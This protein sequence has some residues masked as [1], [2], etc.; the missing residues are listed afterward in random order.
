DTILMRTDRPEIYVSHDAGN[1]WLELVVQGNNFTEIFPHTYKRN[2]VFLLT[3][4]GQVQ[5][6]T[7]QAVNFQTFFPP[8]PPTS[9][10]LEPL[11]F[12][13]AHT[14]WLLW[15][16]QQKCPEPTN[17][18]DCTTLYISKDFGTS[19][20]NLLSDVH[21]CRFV[22]SD[23]SWNKENLIYCERYED[24][25][26]QLL[27]SD[28]FF[29]TWKIL[30]ANVIPEFVK[31]SEYVYIIV[32][33]ANEKGVDLQI[34]DDGLS[35]YKGEFP[36]T[37][38]RF[39]G[40]SI[41][42]SPTHCLFA[43]LSTGNNKGAAYGTLVKDSGRG[44][45]FVS[46]L[47][48]VNRI[49][50]GEVDF[51]RINGLEGIIIINIVSNLRAAIRGEPKK[52]KTKISFNDGADW[53]LIPPPSHDADGLLLGCSGATG[54]C[55][56]HLH[57]RSESRET[58]QIHP[59][60]NER[61]RSRSPISSLQGVGIAIA[62]GNVGESLTGKEDAHMFMTRDGGVTWTHIAEGE[63][64]WAYGVQ[65]SLTVISSAIKETNHIKYSVNE[66]LSW[67]TYQF[68]ENPVKVVHL[69]TD[70]D[71]TSRNFIVWS[72]SDSGLAT[73]AIDFSA[74]L[75]R[76]CNLPGDSLDVDGDFY[77]WIP[78]DPLR[79][80]RSCMFGRTTQYLR[81]KPSAD[82]YNPF[83]IPQ[84][85]ALLANCSCSNEDFE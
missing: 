76:N 75:T 41:L 11:A 38:R 55:S 28:T 13:P 58:L 61:L 25:Q 43:L 12:H 81:K 35:F 18:I 72:V 42:P 46:V 82:C 33:I 47:P 6:S 44:T 85:F 62:I 32:P 22:D 50:T 10:G 17:R 37:L 36:S 16:G 79:S 57:G 9:S 69:S 78:F 77:S 3:D 53:R 56:L 2:I 80:D 49:Q 48:G 66:G 67:K 31:L 71:E 4:S 73:I 19:W 39:T 20:E 15:F 29:R 59:L 65:G 27:S 68:T 8:T 54:T 84:P 63:H 1:R 70:S 83:P 64:M 45:P 5:F 60:L 24:D 30:F 51:E 7:D 40:I 21:K 23:K 52:L 34:T 74:L 26:L 14:S